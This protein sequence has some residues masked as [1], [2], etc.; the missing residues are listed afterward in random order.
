ME[1]P[2]FTKR[3]IDFNRLLEGENRE[4]FV[5]DDVRHWRAVYRDLIQ[6]KEDLLSQTR[7]HIEQVPETRQELGG[8]DI[9]FL[10]AEM[11][12]LRLGLAFWESAKAGPSPP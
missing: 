4:S 7:E 1:P 12:R 6:F 11:Q 5:A 9:P 3:I 10:Q 8:L 2:D